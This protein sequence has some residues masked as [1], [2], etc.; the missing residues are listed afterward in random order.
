MSNSS[1]EHYLGSKKAS[2]S[3]TWTQNETHD[4]PKHNLL[5]HKL[6]CGCIHKQISDTFNTTST[7]SFFPSAISFSNSKI[8]CWPFFREVDGDIL[9]LKHS[10]LYFFI[11]N[12]IQLT[13][14]IS[15]GNCISQL[16]GTLFSLQCNRKPWFL[17]NLSFRR[18]CGLRFV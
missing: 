14:E 5:A 3:L 11:I 13:L 17:F 10:I 9:I 8:N 6:P 12:Q 16:C 2:R 18:T 1:L 4:K 15:T 7:N